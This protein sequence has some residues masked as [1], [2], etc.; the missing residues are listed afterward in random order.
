MRGHGGPC[1]PSGRRR[2]PSAAALAR[3]GAVAAPAPQLPL[4]LRSSLVHLFAAAFVLLLCH[5]GLLSPDDRTLAPYPL[6]PLDCPLVHEHKGAVLL[7]HETVG[8]LG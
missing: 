2:L 7:G 6:Y 1:R 3:R 8:I 5:R 4:L